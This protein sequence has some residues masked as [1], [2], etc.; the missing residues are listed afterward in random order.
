MLLT[1]SAD[2]HVTISVARW[3]FARCSLQDRWVE[4][5]EMTFI[6]IYPLVGED[7]GITINGVALI[8]WKSPIVKQKAF[9]IRKRK[10]LVINV[11]KPGDMSHPIQIFT[12]IT[13]SVNISFYWHNFES[14]TQGFSWRM[15][16]I[17]L[18][19]AFS[20]YYCF[21]I[22]QYERVHQGFLELSKQGE[23]K[24]QSCYQFL[25]YTARIVPSD[26]QKNTI[27]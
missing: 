27:L 13:F 19:W 24:C 5:G 7:A 26:V 18:T 17:G 15:Y 23:N 8:A 16:E 21:L 1:A 12:A 3:S 10:D 2:V 11:P 9:W 25:Y 6:V 22:M 20:Q 4:A 14:F